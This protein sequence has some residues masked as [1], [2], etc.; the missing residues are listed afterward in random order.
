[1]KNPG[2]YV[3]GVRTLREQFYSAGKMHVGSAGACALGFL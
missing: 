2:N 3:G 1:M